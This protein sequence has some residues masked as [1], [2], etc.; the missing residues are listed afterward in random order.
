MRLL[1]PLLLCVSCAT[2]RSTAPQG[3]PSGL[4]DKDAMARLPA[5]TFK[6]GSNNGETDEMPPH[7]VVLKSYLLD[8]TEITNEDYQACVDA[9]VCTPSQGSTDANLNKGRQPAVGVTW[10][11]ANRYCEWV[12]KRLPTEAEFER[13]TRGTSNR[14]Y[15]FEGK[16]VEKSNLRGADDGFEHTAPVGSFP[17]GQSKEAPVLDLTGNAAE[18]VS[19]WYD[20]TYYSTPVSYTH[21]TLPTNREV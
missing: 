17:L 16:A 11:D 18:W 19:D 1:L 3:A 2:A 6:M 8:R 4:T 21:L 7:D 9:N 14:M 10:T 20:P 15:A 5:V 12:G 13:A